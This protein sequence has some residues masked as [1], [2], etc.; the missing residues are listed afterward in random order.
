MTRT[1]AITSELPVPAWVGR[2]TA[3]RGG[4]GTDPATA[5]RRRTPGGSGLAEIVAGVLLLV[6]WAFLWTF[7][8][9]GV[10][11]PAAGLART[12]DRPWLD[13][14]AASPGPGPVDMPPAAP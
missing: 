10:V 11:G 13:V 1:S 5:T 14:S 9:A 2:R 8:I 6:A 12:A 3:T 4:T 7:F